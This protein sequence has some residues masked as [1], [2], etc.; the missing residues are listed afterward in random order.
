[1]FPEVDRL[2]G[3]WRKASSCSIYSARLILGVASG[4]EEKAS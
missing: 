1:M 3:E 2:Q 4:K